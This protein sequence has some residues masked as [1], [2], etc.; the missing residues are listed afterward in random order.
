[1]QA[2]SRVAPGAVVFDEPMARH[3]SLRVGGP[4]DALVRPG[5]REQAGELLRLCARREIPVY[6]LGN[7]FNTLVRDEGIRGVVLQLRNLRG[8]R[9][10]E[11]GRII[12]EAGVTHSS[13]SRLGSSDGISGL[14]FAAGIPGTVGGWLRMNAGIPGREMRDVVEMIEI[15]DPSGEKV[16]ELRTPEL[17]WSYRAL[18]IP[19]GAVV[20]SAVFAT[21]RGDPAEIRARMREQLENRQGSQPLDEASCGSVFKNPEGDHAGRLIEAAGLKGATS[22]GA[23]IS[24]LHA[25]FMVN[26]GGAVATDFLALIERARS[27]VQRQFGVELE[28]EVR[29]YGGDV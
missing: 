17:E 28:P 14:E 15:L 26:L 23:Q 1:M 29:I 5:S 25:N 10:E 7:G 2:L 21:Q 22:G 8:L 16:V 19:D 3:T 9:A 13:L 11:S 18:A 27:E 6:V 24:T 20:L 12:A 4:A